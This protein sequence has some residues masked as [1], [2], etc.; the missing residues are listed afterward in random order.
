M[1]QRVLKNIEDNNWK[2]A[3]FQQRYNVTQYQELT[4]NG[5]GFLNTLSYHLVSFTPLFIY[6][7]DDLLY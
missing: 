3:R 1:N 7:A 6:V 5:H 2:W 4:L